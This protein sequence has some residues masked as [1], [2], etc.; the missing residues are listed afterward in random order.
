MKWIST[1]FKIGNDV[2]QKGW[3]ASRTVWFNIISLVAALAALKGFNLDAND[4]VQLSI[5]VS[6]LGNI[7]LRFRT[8]TR[9]GA[10]SIPGSLPI[11]P[12]EVEIPVQPEPVSHATPVR[13]ERPFDAG[14][15]MG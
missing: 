5:M 4:V 1:I 6:T 11:Q 8:D 15:I 3:Y 13:D 14:S 7:W 12:V 2:Q 9:I 10:S